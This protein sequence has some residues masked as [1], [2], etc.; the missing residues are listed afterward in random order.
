[1]DKLPDDL[2]K[3]IFIK[4]N[5]YD[6]CNSRLVCK[7]YSKLIAKFDIHQIMLEDLMTSTYVLLN[8]TYVPFGMILDWVINYPYTRGTSEHPISR[9]SAYWMAIKC[10]CFYNS[11]IYN[12]IIEWAN[13]CKYNMSDVA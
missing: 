6:K 5:F 2:L 8:K 10:S 7:E 12:N 1:M 13:N 4:L 3:S 9:T 11:V